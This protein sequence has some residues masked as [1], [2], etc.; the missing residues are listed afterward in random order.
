MKKFDLPVLYT[1]RLHL[2]ILTDRQADAVLDYYVRNRDFHQ[3]WFP[4]RSARV[5]TP[6]QQRSNL[7]AEL[8]DFNE[9][10]AV[11][12]WLSHKDDPDRIIG[13]VAFTNIIRGSFCSAFMA[14]HLDRN[15]Q[16]QGLATEACRSALKS[17]FKDFGLHRVEANIMPK[18]LKSQAL[19]NRLG[20]QLEGLSPQYLKINGRWE[21]H[22][23]FVKLSAKQGKSQPKILLR[24]GRVEIRPLLQADAAKLGEFVQRNRQQITAFNPLDLSPE[25]KSGDWHHFLAASR[26]Q[27]EQGRR[28]TLGIFLVDRPDFLAGCIDCTDI[29]PLPFS[30]CKIGFAIDRHLEGRSVMLEALTECIPWLQARYRLKRITA[31][32]LPDNQRSTR[33]L[34]LLGFVSEGLSRRAVW[35][36]GQWL[37]VLQYGL[38]MDEFSPVNIP[39]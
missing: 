19:A 38:L 12:F 35:L 26:A 16:G 24:T 4:A 39:E 13:R 15:C 34:D 30:S 2:S 21:D 18:N 11:P 27:F 23:H 29:L 17:V 14:Y 25:A 22:L 10:R 9:G 1:S 6:A 36:N 31:K 32:V 5:F 20:F 28:M 37:D 7:S 8:N 3:P 33:L